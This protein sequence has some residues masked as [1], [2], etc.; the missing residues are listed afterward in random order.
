MAKGILRLSINRL[1][2]L[3]TV[4][5]DLRHF[6][7]M[8]GPFKSCVKLHEAFAGATTAWELRLGLL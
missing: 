6:Q 4:E 8:A 1:S 3:C 5:R 7:S 2:R